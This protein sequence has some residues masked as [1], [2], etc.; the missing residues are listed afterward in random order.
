MATAVPEWPETLE[1]RRMSFADF[2]ALPENVRAE[3]VDGEAIV[4]PPP[5]RGHN[6]VAFRVARLL[7]DALPD[8]DVAVEPGVRREA[9]R[10]YRIPDVAVFAEFEDVHWSDQTPILAVEILSPSTRNEDTLRKSQEY[11]VAGIGQYWIVDR[12]R[13]TMTVVEAS[14]NDPGAWDI[15]LELDVDHPRGE[16]AVGDHGVVALDLDELLAG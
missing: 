4:T 13:H 10:R 6:K 12:E 5:T 8:L 11:A 14:P 15:V 7:S 1:R 9:A 2:E 16:V 3:Y